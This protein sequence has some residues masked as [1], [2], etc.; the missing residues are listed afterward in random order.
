MKNNGNPHPVMKLRELLLRHLIIHDPK[1]IDL[2]NRSVVKFDVVSQYAY[3]NPKND[4]NNKLAGTMRK[5]K[6]H[7]LRV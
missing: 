3:S 6:S 2:R 5:N 7:M 1:D 4:I